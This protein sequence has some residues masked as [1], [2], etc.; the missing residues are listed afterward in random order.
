MNYVQLYFPQIC[1][2][3]LDLEKNGFRQNDSIWI[4]SSS[5]PITEINQQLILKKLNIFC[6]QWHS[7]QLKVLANTLILLDHFIV[8][9]VQE[10]TG[11]ISGCS[12]DSLFKQ[13]ISLEKEF[14]LSLLN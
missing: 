10:S 5:K 8:V 6:S 3:I 4:F 2:D 7:H 14:T 13:I 12:K 1:S 9:I 11:L